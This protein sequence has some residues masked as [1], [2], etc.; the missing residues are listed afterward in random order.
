MLLNMAKF[1]APCPKQIGNA[2]K[3]I[4]LTSKCDNY[5]KSTIKTPLKL[6]SA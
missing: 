1:N 3:K 6:Q 2:K 5:F 4:F